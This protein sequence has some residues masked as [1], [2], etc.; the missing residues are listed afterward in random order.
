MGEEKVQFDCQEESQTVNEGRRRLL[1]ILAASGGAVAAS[2]VLPEKWVK[3]VVDWGVL[4]VHAQVSP[5]I[6]LS[7]LQVT[8]VLGSGS[9][10]RVSQGPQPSAVV[11]GPS[12]GAVF[13]YDDGG[14]QVNGSTN[15]FASVSPCGELSFSGQPISSIPGAAILNGTGYSGY[16]GF[17]FVTNCITNASLC[18]KLGIGTRLSNQLCGNLPNI[19]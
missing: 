12:F 10:E 7:S 6:V 8:L 1:G 5:T 17:P 3:P 11:I 18:V 14:G 15:L 2:M 9:S 16:I 19:I 13:H 4:P